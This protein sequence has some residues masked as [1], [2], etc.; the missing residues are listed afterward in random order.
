MM[1]AQSK[2]PRATQVRLALRAIREQQ[3]PLA[4]MVQR[5]L[6]VTQVLRVQPVQI[7]LSRVHKGFKA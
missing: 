4:R 3:A 5:V 7:R 2:D 1:Q 6:R